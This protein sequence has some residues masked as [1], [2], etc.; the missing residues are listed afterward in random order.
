MINPKTAIAA[1]LAVAAVADRELSGRHSHRA[2]RSE[3]WPR[4][5]QRQGGPARRQPNRRA[6]RIERP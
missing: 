4:P 6:V 5:E 2:G 3:R 1:V